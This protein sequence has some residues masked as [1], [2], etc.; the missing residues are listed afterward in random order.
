MREK[1]IKNWLSLILVFLVCGSRLHAQKI[2]ID[3]GNY[4]IW[5]SIELDHGTK[6]SNDGRFI[7]YVIR[8]QPVGRGNGTTV[9]R[10]VSGDW[11]LQLPGD[12]DCHFSQDSRRFLFLRHDSLGIGNL[13]QTTIDYIPGVSSF[14]IYDKGL[15]DNWLVYQ[16]KANSQLVIRDAAIGEK[17]K[18]EN[19]KN[20]WLDEKTGN[21]VLLVNSNG[22]Q[23]LQ[24]GNLNDPAV[25]TVWS[26]ELK[27]Q[28][29]FDA[30]GNRIA[31]MGTDSKDKTGSAIF[32]YRKDG[33]LAHQIAD[34]LTQGI[35]GKFEITRIAV[36]DSSNVYFTLKEKS[37]TSKKLNPKAVSLD[38]Y[39]YK[40]AILQSEQ[41]L[42]VNRAAEYAAIADISLDKVSP[43]SLING[44][45]VRS[46][47]RLDPAAMTQSCLFITKTDDGSEGAGSNEWNWNPHA[48]ATV[49]RLSLTDGSMV[50]VSK[51]LT[52]TNTALYTYL[53]SSLDGKFAV[54]FDL[55]DRNYYSYEIATGKR[56]NL[57]KSFKTHWTRFNY[58]EGDDELIGKFYPVGIAGFLKSNK[59][60]LIYDQ[61][62]IY[63][64]DLEGNKPPVCLTNYYGR[65]HHTEFRFTITDNQGQKNDLSD[66]QIIVVNAFN[67]RT[68]ADGFYTVKIGNQQ[69]PQKLSLQHRL[70]NGIN[71]YEVG[72]AHVPLKAR[73]ANV[74]ILQSQK[75]NEA[76]NLV[77]TND[78]KNF[79]QLTDLAPQKPYNWL[80]SG[81][82]TWKTFNGTISQGILYKPENFDPKKK[83]P[84]IFYYYERFSNSINR[85]LVPDANGATIDIP[86]FVSNGYL[87][88]IPDI[89][90]PLN[91][92]QGLGVYNSVVSAANYMAK[93]PWVDSKHMGINGHSRGGFQTDYLITH[94]NLFA[95]AISGAGYCDAISLY[96]H[97]GVD[98]ISGGG[99][100]EIGH[101]RM[102]ATLWQ[103][104][105]LYLEN[106]PI[107][108]A[109]KVTTP[110]LMMNNKLDDNIPFTQGIEFFSSLRR[111][112]KKAW[113]LQYDGEGH[114]ASNRKEDAVDFQIRMQQFFDHYLKG[115]PPPVWMTKGVPAKLKQIDTGLK[116]DQSGAIP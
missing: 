116:L 35:A 41:L 14:K 92:G 111:L 58:G 110:V 76:P 32:Y 115:T 101:Q 52:A 105:K 112:S 113:M 90:Y 17:R 13:G 98:G 62:D 100:Y 51:N 53:R 89:H 75:A 38:L 11:K 40:D 33:E 48:S 86:T 46:I 77:F 102:G 59:S 82:I 109:D 93:M 18:L 104:P 5:P 23:R 72:G 66:G 25:K 3:T 83:Y 15:N 6:I 60:V 81:L 7:V 65:D 8:N 95:A 63:E 78:F 16:T 21:L 94:T 34:D 67:H 19:V 28:L 61:R 64:L 69:D 85:F 24:W 42:K 74:Y 114:S 49:Y 96:T 27:G 22:V 54:Y 80:T 1:Y 43:V 57:T 108:L 73:D 37:T 4:G 29:L 107:L 103:N 44:N 50:P 56:H 30:T 99:Q 91:T 45:G 68:K 12:L 31:F 106:S 71:E 55:K 36:V 9:V 97:N 47:T 10:S 79:G 87:V 88:F 20:Y 39:S 70:L 84:I 2:L 26:G